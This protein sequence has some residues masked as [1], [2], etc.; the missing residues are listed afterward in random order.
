MA[1]R[2]RKKRNWLRTALFYLLF[3]LVVW[4]AAVL[5]WF[6][7]S[8]LTGPFFKAADK[9]KAAVKRESKIEA[10]EKTDSKKPEPVQEK[11]L[12]EDRRKLEDILKQRQ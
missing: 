9:P 6:L 3:P 1:Q 10:R 7:W 12:D 5:L 4:L 8:D 11:I 2:K